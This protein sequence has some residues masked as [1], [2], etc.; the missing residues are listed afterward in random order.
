MPET[1]TR[2]E[3]ARAVDAPETF[4]KPFFG[5]R[6]NLENARSFKPDVT[7]EPVGIMEALSDTEDAQLGQAFWTYLVLDA[8]VDEADQH[9]AAVGAVVDL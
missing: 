5:E 2:E 9:V 6:F 7:M 8:G 1:T 4:D 3:I